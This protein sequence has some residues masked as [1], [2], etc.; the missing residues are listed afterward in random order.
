MYSND[1]YEI[2]FLSC[3]INQKR[4]RRSNSTVYHEIYFVSCVLN[5]II[6]YNND[7]PAC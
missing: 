7:I 5:Q 6:V 4:K 3:V 1:Y 2:Y